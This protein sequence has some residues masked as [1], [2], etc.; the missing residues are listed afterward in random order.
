M[1]M[2]MTL[3]EKIRPSFP[4]L[5]VVVPVFNEGEAVHETMAKLKEL[6]RTHNWEVII[7]DD[8]STDDTVYQVSKHID[9]S[10]MQLLR[11]HYN[12]GYG[13][14]L[15]TGIRR[16]CA[17]YVATMDSDGQHD[18]HELLK[19][20]PYASDFDLAVG[21]RTKLL[22]SHLWRMPG[23]WFLG[24]LANYLTR[25]SIP[26]LNS[27]MRL[28]RR[29]VILKYLHLC[30]DRFS[31]STTSTLIFF[32]RGYQVTYVPIEIYPRKGK[33][34]VK[35]STGFET[36]ILIL[37][38]MILF[39]PLR[40]FVPLSVIFGGLGI[41]WAIPYAIQQRG[42]SVGALLLIITGL[43]TFMLGLLSDQIAAIRKERFE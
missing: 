23:K 29:E 20:L 32:N 13:A 11:H 15:K 12:R 2:T 10:N 33:S 17:P 34:T 9:G 27:G 19:L 41:L 42:I 35:L 14:A 6:S 7:V 39:E 3:S 28:F 1:A 22:H 25:Q 43:L 30:S 37:R 24:W 38:I 5:S 18:P 36:I 16:A 21:H 31:F 4:A 26:D 40:I 8:G